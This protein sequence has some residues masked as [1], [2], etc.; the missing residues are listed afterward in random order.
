MSPSPESPTIRADDRPALWRRGSLFAVVAAFLVGG[1]ALRQLGHVRSAYLPQWVMFVGYGLD[2]CAVQ[3]SEVGPDGAL[4]PLDRFEALGHERWVKAPTSVKRV[5]DLAAGER[6]G[7]QLCKA[8]GP[9]ADIRMS[10]RCAARTGWSQKADND[11]NLCIRT[12]KP[13]P[14]R[15]P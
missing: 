11:V 4:S 15:A 10:L 13:I 9:G 1:P 8:K 7:R 3:Y 14:K 12:A 5:S 2:V 6:L